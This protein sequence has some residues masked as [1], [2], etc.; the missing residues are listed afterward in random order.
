MNKKFKFIILFV[1]FLI[2]I[3]FIYR[4]HISKRPMI[5]YYHHWIVPI[6]DEEKIKDLMLKTSN[7]SNRLLNTILSDHDLRRSKWK[8]LISYYPKK[9]NHHHYVFNELVDAI[10]I[11]YLGNQPVLGVDFQ[12]NSGVWSLVFS[13]T[14]EEEELIKDCLAIPK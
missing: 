6:Q 8:L 1:T 3:T 10:Y 13:L 14:R 11:L 2:L 4:Y 9:E 7:D 5:A 12:D